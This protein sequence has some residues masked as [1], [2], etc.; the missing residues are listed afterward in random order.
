[1]LTI[2]LLRRSPK[3]LQLRSLNRLGRVQ[4]RVGYGNETIIKSSLST[5]SDSSV[6]TSS[7]SGRSSIAN[8]ADEIAAIIASRLTEKEITLVLRSFTCALNRPSR[9]TRITTRSKIDVAWINVWFAKLYSDK[10]LDFFPLTIPP[11]MDLE[12]SG[13]RLYDAIRNANKHKT[14]EFFTNLAEGKKNSSIT[15]G[16]A[17]A[18]TMEEE[19][20][21]FIND[22]LGPYGIISVFGIP[23]ADKAI[24]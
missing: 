15:S 20:N 8:N 1:M 14:S 13:R 16:L 19:I 18:A 24:K 17:A 21:I 3:C 22:G 11:P 6:N 12:V 10:N 4:S 2:S 7:A 23:A 9:V 5:I